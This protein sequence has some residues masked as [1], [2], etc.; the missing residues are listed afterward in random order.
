MDRG[1]R[2]AMIGNAQIMKGALCYLDCFD[3]WHR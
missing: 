3:R 2:F 1:G